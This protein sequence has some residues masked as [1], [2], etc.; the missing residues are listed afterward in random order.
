MGSNPG[1]IILYDTRMNKEISV[2]KG[3]ESI[4]SLDFHENL[5][6]FNSSSKLLVTDMRKIGHEFYSKKIFNKHTKNILDLSFSPSGNKIVSGSADCTIRVY[7]LPNS[8]NNDNNSNNLVYYN[9]RMGMVNGVTFS[10]CNNFIISGS[11]DGSLRLWKSHPNNPDRVLNFREKKSRVKNENLKNAFKGVSELRRIRN[12]VFLPKGL[13]NEI[14]QKR[15]MDKK[16]G[17]YKE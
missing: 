10:N 7:S 12:H 17:Y 11:D 5:L 8:N 3:Q 15:E 2:I 9:Q 1:G 14:K 6:A 16:R 13:K 4:N